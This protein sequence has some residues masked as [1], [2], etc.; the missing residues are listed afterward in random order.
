MGIEQDIEMGPDV[1]VG[2]V[3]S[4]RANNPSSANGC[5][6]GNPLRVLENQAA[7]SPNFENP[8][9]CM[10]GPRGGMLEQ[11]DH[12]HHGTPEGETK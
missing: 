1:V 9:D 7:D 11:R 8:R 4:P 3:I 5:E 6:V 10:A 12:S 2:G